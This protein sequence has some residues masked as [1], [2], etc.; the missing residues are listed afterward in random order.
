MD[1]CRSHVK[2]HLLKFPKAEAAGQRA[3]RQNLRSYLNGPIQAL[4]S[5]EFK[6]R[7]KQ[8]EGMTPE[9]RVKEVVGW[10]DKLR[11]PLLCP[12]SFHRRMP[13]A[14]YPMLPTLSFRRFSLMSRINFMS[15]TRTA[16]PLPVVL[17][18]SSVLLPRKLLTLEPTS[19]S[20]RLAKAARR[21]SCRVVRKTTHRSSC[22]PDSRHM[23]TLTTTAT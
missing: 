15:I 6:E 4:I 20:S 7:K 18:S 22:V 8:P 10:C 3:L 23:T 13:F 11:M 12:G 19:S 17:H 1:E 5:T 9:D 2:A 21:N 16:A 14:G